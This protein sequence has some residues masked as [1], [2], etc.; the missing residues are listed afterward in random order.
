MQPGTYRIDVE[1]S[2]FKHFTQTNITIEVGSSTR[3]DA[4]VQVGTANETVEVTSQA[5]LLETQQAT[6]GQVVEGR[7]V[8]EM[9]L[10]GRNVLNLLA[11]APG[12]VPLQ[13][14]QAASAASGLMGTFAGGNYMISGGIPDAGIEFLDGGTI[15]TGYINA[16]AFVPSQDAVQ[17]FKIESN[18]ISP[19][20][21]GT[22]DGVVTMV[23]KS[24]T[25][26][27]HGSVFEYLRNTLL[28]SNTFFGNRAALARP[29]FIQNQFGATAG[30]PIKRNKLFF[31]GSWE[32]VRTALGTT[33]TY[34]V[35]TGA[36]VSAATTGN[37]SSITTPIT[38]PT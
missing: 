34:T 24:G 22:E 21:G 23:T 14:V 18:N 33:T 35:P 2:G 5:A 10:N 28:N 19:E 32:A 4:R 9:P 27:L 38:D 13:N 16:L 12:V 20:Y 31:F 15:N 37:L 29:P 6:V 17:E 11:L 25:N 36:L 3:T 26:Q 7:S 8:E 1:A 30:G